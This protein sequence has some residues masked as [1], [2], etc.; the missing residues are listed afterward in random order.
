MKVAVIG[1]GPCGALTALLL[2]ESGYSVDLIGLNDNQASETPNLESRLKLV[3]GDSSTYDVNQMLKIEIDGEIGTFHRSKVTGGFSNVWGATW[4][5]PLIRQDP[6]WLAHYEKVTEKVFSSLGLTDASK[7]QGLAELAGCD[8]LS[9]LNQ[10]GSTK[11]NGFGK[12]DLAINDSVCKCVS[13]GNGYCIHGSVWNS[14]SLTKECEKYPNFRLLETIDVQKI[15]SDNE[16]VY[17]NHNSAKLKYD[18]ITLAAGPLGVSEILLNSEI[19]IKKISLS[20]TRMA[21]L[22]YFRFRLNTGHT[23]AF[24]FSQYRF[25]LKDSDGEIEAH[26][27]LYAH[28]ELYKKRILGKIPQGMSLLGKYL[29]NI[30]TPHMGIAIIYLNS[31][32][33][34]SLEI[35]KDQYERKLTITVKKPRYDKKGLRKR[36]WVAFNHLG[37]IPL[38]PAMSWAKVGESYHLGAA[39]DILNEFGFLKLE[40]RLSIAGSFALPGILPGPI[41]HAAMAQ[42]SRLVEQIIYQNLESI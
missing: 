14:I 17:I 15:E 38:L 40:P 29:I 35:S 41:T 2:L 13:S 16:G 42:S 32:L 23:G 7:M 25:D 36:I 28:S 30:L 11:V 21:Y 4:D 27:Q 6:S 33:S 9:F 31:S 8:C 3:D 24:A 26:I 22:P 18:A 20:E 34:E 19:E 39:P 10:S 37:V 12:T 5:S 1:S